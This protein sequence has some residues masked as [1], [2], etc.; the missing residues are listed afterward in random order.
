MRFTR[1]EFESEFPVEVGRLWRFHM[2]EDALGLLTPPV[3]HLEVLDPGRGLSEGSVIRFR[4][5]RG[6]LRRRWTALHT[7]VDP[8]RGF[9]DVA[10][11]GPFPFWEHRHEFEV[12]GRGRARLRD[13][14]WYALPGWIPRWPTRALLNMILHGVF[15]WR[16]RRTAELVVR[17][18][19]PYRPRAVPDS[20]QKLIWQAH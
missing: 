19:P 14:I 4:V 1:F 6:L 10:L 18:R 9:T 11:E 17:P 13:V 15:S 2:R 8:E 3:M 16:H 7:G 20:R 12:V 5:G